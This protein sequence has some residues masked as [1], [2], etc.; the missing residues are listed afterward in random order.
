MHGPAETA[1]DQIERRRGDV[2]L[3]FGRRGFAGRQTRLGGARST[4]GNRAP[5][6]AQEHA[7]GLQLIKIAADRFLCDAEQS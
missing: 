1:V 5:V 6:H 4:R 3:G 2:F 7:V